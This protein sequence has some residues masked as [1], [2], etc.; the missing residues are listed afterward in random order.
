MKGI[1]VFL[2]F[3]LV[4]LIVVISIA[5]AYT[6]VVPMINRFQDSSTMDSSITNLETIYSTIQEVAS[7]A[8]GSKR[9]IYLTTKVPIFVDNKT[10]WI[11][12]DYDLTSDLK[13]SGKIGRVYLEENPKFL[14][15]F[16]FYKENENASENW[17]CSSNCYVESGKYVLEN[18]L[19]WHKYSKSLKNFY[20]EGKAEGNDWEIYSLPINP[21]NLVLY[22]TFDDNSGNYT[23][24]YSL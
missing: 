10:N 1:S 12:F 24:D 8:E 23:W 7:E 18:S 22:L 5:I 2:S 15:Y 6:Y 21:K 13:I 17:N 4:F 20:L 9:T 14:D 16:N 19:A 11:Y 3:I